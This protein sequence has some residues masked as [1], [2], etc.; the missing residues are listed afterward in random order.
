MATQRKS[1]KTKLPS[2]AEIA[3][4]EKRA[5]DLLWKIFYTTPKIREFP[6]HLAL[7]LSR[8]TEKSRMAQMLVSHMA[9]RGIET[10]EELADKLFI[11]NDHIEV[12]EWMRF[13]VV[14]HPCDFEKECS[15][16]IALCDL[17]WDLCRK[18][19]VSFRTKRPA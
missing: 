17:E 15:Y 2:V 9:D 11:G 5:K 19:Y 3:R 12:L 16:L 6:E 8:I 18:E 13:P 7:G 10:V 14:F 1:R 4:R